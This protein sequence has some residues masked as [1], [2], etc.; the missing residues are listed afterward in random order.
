MSKRY[1][2]L[3]FVAQMLLLSYVLPRQ[4]RQGKN[5]KYREEE[6]TVGS[7]G[8]NGKNGYLVKGVVIG[9]VTGALAGLLF[10]PKSGKELRRDIKH[11]GSDALRDTKDFY[12]DTQKKAKS[13]LEDT[14]DWLSDAC[15]KTKKVFVRN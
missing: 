6:T 15:V 13:A 2:I 1:V 14:K 5:S 3:F 11:K 4:K 8:K 9:G 12:L 7:N 10:A